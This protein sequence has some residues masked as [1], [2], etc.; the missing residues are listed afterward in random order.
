MDSEDTLFDSNLGNH[1]GK[2]IA[3][4]YINL[5]EDDANEGNSNGE[6][7]KSKRDTNKDEDFITDLVNPLVQESGV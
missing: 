3:G 5:G 6:L 1:V 7:G 2:N 4:D